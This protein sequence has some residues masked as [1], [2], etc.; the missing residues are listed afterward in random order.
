MKQFRWQIIIILLTG[1]VVGLLLLSEQTGFRLVAPV[2][3][4]G[5]SYTEALVGELQRLNPVLDY[6]NSVDRDVD[7]L[8]FSSLIDYDTQGLPKADLAESWGISYD[9]LSY[10]FVIREDAFW[11]DGNPV[12]ADDILFTINLM[13]DPDSVLPDDIKDFWQGVEIIPLGDKQ[14]QFRLQEP[15]A[16]FLDYLNFGILPNHILSGMTYAEMINSEF[17]LKPIGSGPYKFDGLT[18]EEG[19]I[20]GVILSANTDF[21]EKPP[22]ISEIVFRY[23]GSN[24]EAFNAYLAGNVLGVSNISSQILNDALVN[25]DLSLYSIVDPEF[26]MIILNLNNN[27][28]RF[29]QDEDVRRSLLMGLDR[30]GMIDRVLNGQGIIADVPI[31]LNSWAYY[32]GNQSVDQNVQESINLLKGAGYVAEDG[33]SVRSKDGNSLTFSIVHPNDAFHTQIAQSIKSDWEK[34]GVNVDLLAVPYDA[35]ILD[36]LQPLTYEAA[37]IDINYFRSPDPD[38]YPFWDQSQQTSGQNYSQWENRV[39]SQYLEEARVSQDLE[40]RAKLY[41]NFQIVFSDELPALP[42]FYTTYSFAVDQSIQGIR[43]GSMYDSSD[44]FWNITDWFLITE[45]GQAE[46]Q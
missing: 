8:I 37:L 29:F 7:R 2:P 23:Y 15:F 20:S 12:I 19:M 40:A 10:N 28:V 43:V 13:R 21:Y 27:N 32:S 42:L 38:P 31:L 33:G 5:G 9:G 18:S 39:V 30:K 24:E 6:Y 16:P 35:L 26:S 11:H 22:F 36:H 46:T 4:R 3:I 41:R 25:E 14:V 17:N 34:L 1:L 45:S 44:R